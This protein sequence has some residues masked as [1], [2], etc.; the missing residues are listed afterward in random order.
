MPARK[1]GS[2]FRSTLALPPV[3][4]GGQ[5]SKINGAYPRSPGPVSQQFLNSGGRAAGNVSIPHVCALRRRMDAA[6]GCCGAHRV[7]P[8]RLARGGGRYNRHNR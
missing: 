2:S 4:R 1:A 5:I 8:E 7:I 3:V 6:C